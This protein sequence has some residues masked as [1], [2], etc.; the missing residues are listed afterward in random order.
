MVTAV[1]DFIWFG[2]RGETEFT[3][4]GCLYMFVCKVDCVLAKVVALKTSKSKCF[5]LQFYCD[6]NTKRL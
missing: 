5:K 6:D 3:K 2:M 1:L 4:V